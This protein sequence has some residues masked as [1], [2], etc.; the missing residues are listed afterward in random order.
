MNIQDLKQ[1]DVPL[2]I[3]IGGATGTGKSTVATE[4]AYRLGITRATSTDFIRQTI[5]ALSKS[6]GDI[7]IFTLSPAVS[8]TKRLRIFPEIVASTWCLFANSTRNIVPGR[9][10]CTTPS[11]S[12]CDSF[13]RW[14]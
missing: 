1:L 6:Y 9:T 7:S 2:V 5:R 3:L 12:T 10:V 8:R 13:T 14:N 4:I 11:T